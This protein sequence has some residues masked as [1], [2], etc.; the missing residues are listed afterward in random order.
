MTYRLEI[1]RGAEGDF[2]RIYDYLAGESEQGATAWFNSYEKHLLQI[3]RDAEVYPLAT[4]PELAEMEIRQH[5]FRSGTGKYYRALY[6]IEE[7]IV[8]ILAIRAP[9]D[10]YARKDLVRRTK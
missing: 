7:R 8:Y 1:T 6:L 4:E 10:N 9:G 2:E 5:L 3:E